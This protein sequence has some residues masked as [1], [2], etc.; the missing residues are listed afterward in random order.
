M[1]ATYLSSVKGL[2]G[3]RVNEGELR[4]LYKVDESSHKK[5]AKKLW[6][7][8][9]FVDLFWCCLLFVVCHFLVLL[10]RLL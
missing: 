2:G 9:L 3:K 5:I 1:N 7:N 8:P 4:S 6:T 10:G